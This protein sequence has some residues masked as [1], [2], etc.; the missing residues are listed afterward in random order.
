MKTKFYLPIVLFTLINQL[1]AT[2]INYD[3]NKPKEQ[4]NILKVQPLE[5]NSD[6]GIKGKFLI[7]AGAGFNIWATS[8]EIKYELSDFWFDNYGY[9][10]DITVTA[11]PM[12][13]FSVD[14]GILKNLSA[15]VALGYQT[16]KVT[17]NDAP[18]QFIDKWTRIHVAARVDYHII[19]KENITMYTG[20]KFGYNSYT[21]TS[22][23]TP[24]NPAY[25][26]EL[27][28][29]P[30]PYSIQAHFGFSYFFSD[31]VGFNTEVGLGVG[32]PYIGAIGLAV[33]L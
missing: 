3:I 6:D 11:P 8:M 2:T 27:D 17:I 5:G 25:K 10:E 19:A 22:T 26:A 31:V 24:I 30:N 14:Y 16:A 9:Y 12:L 4:R 15:G 21:M 7:G 1:N 32:G 29:Y 23:V 33:K 13:N 20:L 18:F 28:V